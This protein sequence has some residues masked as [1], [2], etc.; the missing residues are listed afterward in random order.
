MLGGIGLW[1]L[2][3]QSS[4]HPHLA[5]KG[6]PQQQVSGS[7]PDTDTDTDTAEQSVEQEHTVRVQISTVPD[8]AQIYLDGK[9][10]SNPFDAELQRDD[11]SHELL[12]KRE[13]YLAETRKMVL[14][15]PQRIVI[16]LSLEP[17]PAPKAKHPAPQS[18]P[19]P[20]P[21]Q[22]PRPASGSSSGSSSEST[23]KPIRDLERSLKK[24]F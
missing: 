2:S 5:P 17:P 14:T 4:T 13:G 23:P 19:K 8:D 12:V 9:L 7:E 24:I 11:K 6:V 22:S 21:A 3:R 20:A 1:F 16:P 18:S 10:L 15:D